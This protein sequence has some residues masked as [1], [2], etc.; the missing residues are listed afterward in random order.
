MAAAGWDD[1]I[2]LEIS[3]AVWNRPEFLPIGAAEFSYA[4]L[5]GAFRAAGVARG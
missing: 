1:Y 3:G 4:T 5:D 2:T